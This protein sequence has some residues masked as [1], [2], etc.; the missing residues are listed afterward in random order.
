MRWT[1][2]L[3]PGAPGVRSG[4]ERTSPHAPNAK[5]KIAPNTAALQSQRDCDPSVPLRLEF[6]TPQTVGS[7][8]FSVQNSVGSAGTSLILAMYGRGLAF[9]GFTLAG[10]QTMPEARLTSA[11]GGAT[12]RGLYESEK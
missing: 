8:V 7:V 4:N 12:T 6:I 3:P 11:S 9:C 1:N 5:P 10:Q 2:T